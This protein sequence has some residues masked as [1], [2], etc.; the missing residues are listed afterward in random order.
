MALAAS[1][2][3]R[4]TL[5]LKEFSTSLG[6]GDATA[7]C[8]H[9]LEF[10]AE[11]AN[12]T[13]DGEMNR[14]YSAAVALTTTPTDVDL[15]GALSSVLATGTT[16]SFVDLVGVFIVNTSTSGNIEV[17]G[18]ANGVPAFGATNDIIRVL[19]GGC[20]FW[21]APTGVAVTN[22]TGD[23]LQLAASTGT[24]NCK[25]VIWGRNA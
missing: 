8:D 10:A 25:I 15:S 23:I 12:G 20:I 13:A 3:L 14:V 9:F 16:V 18:D 5:D 19:P 7:R 4:V 1:G 24:V 6:V 11:L 22:S 2:K 21:Y 17:G